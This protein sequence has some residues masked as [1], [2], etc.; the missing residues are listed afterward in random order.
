MTI[1]GALEVI[2]ELERSSPSGVLIGASTVLDVAMARRCRDAGA[3]FLDSKFRWSNSLCR[4]G[5]S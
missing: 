1:P 3:Q 4:R 2:R 5:F